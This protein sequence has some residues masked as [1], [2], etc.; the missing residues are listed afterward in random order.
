VPRRR[1][2]YRRTNLRPYLLIILAC[3]VV[4]LVMQFLYE[5]PDK[6]Q[7]YADERLEQAVRKAV[8]EEVKDATK[9]EG[10]KGRP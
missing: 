3:A 7:D 2:W 10:I 8:K 5:V 6:I 1:R 9:K 4:A